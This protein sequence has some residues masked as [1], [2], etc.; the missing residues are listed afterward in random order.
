[1]GAANSERRPTPRLACA[2]PRRAAIQVLL[3]C[4]LSFFLNFL[5]VQTH[6]Q[7]LSVAWR[8]IL[9]LAV[10]SL[11]ST[12]CPS[13]CLL[14]DR[15]IDRSRRK[16]YERRSPPWSRLNRLSRTGRSGRFARSVADDGGNRIG[17]RLT[18]AGARVPRRQ[19]DYRFC[20]LA[21]HSIPTARVHQLVQNDGF[22]STTDGAWQALQHARTPAASL[23]V[24]T[25]RR[26]CAVVLLP[27]LL[28]A[29]DADEQCQ[30]E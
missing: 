15:L 8:I 21:E 2:R 5:L 4:R 19:R 1:M 27:D 3:G 22:A 6:R 14:V 13:A 10:C 30:P 18:R 12:V 9:L 20:D 29:H 28:A 25:R 26:A 11:A 24:A 7:V 17:Q 16:I 23:A